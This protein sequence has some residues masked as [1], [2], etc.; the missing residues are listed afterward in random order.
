MTA[1]AIPSTSWT[2][3]VTGRHCCGFER[4]AS[5]AVGADLVAGGLTRLKPVNVFQPKHESSSE[6]SKLD[7][8]RSVK[9]AFSNYSTRK[10]PDLVRLVERNRELPDLATGDLLEL[11]TTY[12]LS[13]VVKSLGLLHSFDPQRHNFPGSSGGGGGGSPEALGGVWPPLKNVL[14][15]LRQGP[16]DPS[17]VGLC[18]VIRS[19]F[20]KLALSLGIPHPLAAP[21]PETPGGPGSPSRLS[22]HLVRVPL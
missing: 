5:R 8:S 10:L 20:S 6:A 15:F 14:E 22:G 4:T 9:Y 13:D 3:Q 16:P 11:V 2:T 1:Q 12:G 19:A 21:P 7:G 17:R 18:S